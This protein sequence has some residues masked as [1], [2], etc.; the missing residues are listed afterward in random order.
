MES[1]G[2]QDDVFALQS[3]QRS[4][5]RRRR[6]NIRDDEDDDSNDRDNG[7][8]NEIRVRSKS[9][10]VPTRQ[11]PSCATKEGVKYYVD[12]SDDSMLYNKSF[13]LFF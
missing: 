3:D 6:R 8:N 9:S 12:D 1:L 13:V 7:G 11:M 4:A 10:A 2:I 5:M